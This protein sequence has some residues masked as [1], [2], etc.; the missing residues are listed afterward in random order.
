[1]HACGAV[2][3]YLEHARPRLCALWDADADVVFLLWLAAG[4]G[5]SPST[6]ACLTIYLVVTWLGLH[7]A[8]DATIG[9]P[10]PP[11]PRPNFADKP[12]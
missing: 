9:D 3:L 2:S 5:V 7:G 6:T 11:A 4:G 10:M 12:G 1:M 8:P